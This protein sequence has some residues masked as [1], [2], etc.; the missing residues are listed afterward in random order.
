MNRLGPSQSLDKLTHFF[1]LYVDYPL[2]EIVTTK[3]YTDKKPW[4]EK[5]NERL[6]RGL[7]PETLK[8]EG[9]Q[10][11]VGEDEEK[12][13]MIDQECPQCGNKKMYYTSRQMRSADEGE[14]VIYECPKCS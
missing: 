5:F 7:N 14:T 3:V 8:M 1:S 12:R 11:E 13:P 2:Q 4:L 10:D 9:D 6:K